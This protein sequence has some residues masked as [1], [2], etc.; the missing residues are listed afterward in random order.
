MQGFLEAFCIIESKKKGQ[1]ILSI[2]DKVYTWSIEDS[3]KAGT[4]ASG[5]ICKTY[6][7][8]DLT[9]LLEN[10]AVKYMIII[11]NFVIR[12]VVSLIMAFC[13]CDT[14]SIKLQFVTNVVFICQFF[15]TGVLPMLCTANLTG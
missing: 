11:I 2:K 9:T 13:G 7:T 1:S 5:K 4:L 12:T 10:N 14:E 15:N 6:V 3:D 8:D